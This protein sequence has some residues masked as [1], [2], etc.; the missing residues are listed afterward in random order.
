MRRPPGGKPL[1]AGLVIETLTHFGLALAGTVWIAGP[2]LVAFGLHSSVW[3]AVEVTL[4]QRAV[5]EELRGRVQS[6]FMMLA[7]GGSA[8]GALIGGPMARWL[9]IT[10]PFWVSAVV[11][12]LLTV[13]AWRLFGRRLISPG[14]ADRPTATV[15]AG[16]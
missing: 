4:R 15:A 11:M 1:R 9:G 13:S 10:G 14:T 16:A 3:G 5:P 6:V 12:A 7:V 2:V 8:V